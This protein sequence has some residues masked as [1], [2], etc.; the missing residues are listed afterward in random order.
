MFMCFNTVNDLLHKSKWSLLWFI[1]GEEFAGLL[2]HYY[3]AKRNDV[4]GVAC[5]NEDGSPEIM[6]MHQELE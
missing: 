5:L 2:P 4:H 1:R 6:W 3:F